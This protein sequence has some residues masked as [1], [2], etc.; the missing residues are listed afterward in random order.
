MGLEP[1]VDDGEVTEEDSADDMDD[2][3]KF[4]ENEVGTFSGAGDDACRG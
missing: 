1:S 4:Q 3:F 2:T